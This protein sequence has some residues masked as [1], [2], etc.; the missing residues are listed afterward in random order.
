MGKLQHDFGVDVFFTW[1]VIEH[2][3]ANKLIVVAGGWNDVFG[4]EEDKSEYLRLM[5]MYTMLLKQAEQESV[6][7]DLSDLVE[8]NSTIK[9]EYQY[10]DISA[11]EI[12]TLTKRDSDYDSI[13]INALTNDTFMEPQ[14]DPNG[15]AR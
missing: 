2:E 8:P 12:N 6:S 5:T 15:D 3:G 9:I 14:A 13:I 7:L 11:N 1:G 10:E 4:V